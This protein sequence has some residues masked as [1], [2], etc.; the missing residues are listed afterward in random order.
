MEIEVNGFQE[1][2]LA[3]RKAVLCSD[4]MTVTIAEFAA[5]TGVSIPTVRRGITAG[6]IPTIRVGAR[7][8]I[9]RQYVERLLSVQGD[10]CSG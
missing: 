6:T 7:V 4:R 9:S 1:D 2:L 5:I 10:T 8:L 3:I